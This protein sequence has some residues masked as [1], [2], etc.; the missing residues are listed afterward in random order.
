LT[1]DEK[2]VKLENMFQ[3]P[4]FIGF[5]HGKVLINNFLN[6]VKDKGFERI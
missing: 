3:D 2:K 5:G 6:H 1:Q 4:D